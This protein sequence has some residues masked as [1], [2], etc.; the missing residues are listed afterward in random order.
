MA[1]LSAFECMIKYRGHV[2]FSVSESES[3]SSRRFFDD[4]DVVDVVVV[5]DNAIVGGV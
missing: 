1:F 3:L 5:D 4:V 2:P